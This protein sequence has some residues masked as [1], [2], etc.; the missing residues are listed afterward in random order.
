MALSAAF[1]ALVRRW[2][3]KRVGNPFVQPLCAAA[4]AGVIGAAAVRLHLSMRKA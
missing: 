3:A 4:I 1:G 2:L